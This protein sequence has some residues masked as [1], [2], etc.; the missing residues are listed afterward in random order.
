MLQEL[1][2]LKGSSSS[3][4]GSA[5]VQKPYVVGFNFEIN[6]NKKQRN[7]LHEWNMERKSN[8]IQIR[9]I[10]YQDTM[11]RATLYLIQMCVCVCALITAIISPEKNIIFIVKIFCTILMNLTCL[12]L[13]GNVFLSESYLSVSFSLFFKHCCYFRSI[14][15]WYKSLKEYEIHLFVYTHT[16]RSGL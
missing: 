1:R 13:L 6:S 4:E 9:L 16:H 7:C 8:K 2:F 5:C 14:K 12:Y 11:H 3:V 15:D 10:I